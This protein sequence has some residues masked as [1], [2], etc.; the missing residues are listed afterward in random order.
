MA[1][2]STGVTTT[3]DDQSNGTSETAAAGGLR[4]RGRLRDG[5][6]VA[7][8]ANAP[9]K[10]ALRA[11]LARK[12]IYVVAIN[13]RR[14]FAPGIDPTTLATGLTQLAKLLDA[15]VP[16]TD[17]LVAVAASHRGTKAGE[18]LGVALDR[19]RRGVANGATLA[20]SFAAVGIVDRFGVELIHVGESTGRLTEVLSAIAIRLSRR[21]Q[22]R[23]ALQKALAYPLTVLAIALL[24]TVV[25]LVEIVPRFAEIYRQFGADLP[26]VTA[27]VVGV[28]D[29]IR[30]SLVYLIAIGALG[31]ALVIVGRR[32]DW[33]MPAKVDEALLALPIVGTI[34]RAGQLADAVR[35]LLIAIES[36]MPVVDALDLAH[37]TSHGR[38]RREL[39]TLSERVQEGDS[40]ARA[41]A[42]LGTFPPIVTTMVAAGETAGDLAPMLRHVADQYD[43]VRERSTAI[44]TALAEPLVMVVLGGL[45]GGILIA[46]YLPIF[47]LGNVLGGS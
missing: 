39:H 15:S 20:Q 19:A 10:R 3:V 24:V 46:L 8:D 2:T 47:G 16:L 25:M 35:T 14:R 43:E 28:S 12:G 5:A 45:V 13:R 9:G 31:G 29:T 11:M 4:W 27:F 23:K 40:I 21:Q 33:A 37:S 6:S 41:M 42:S 18:K 17:A 44:L 1:G 36:G 32:I 26:A 22:N 7:G 34:R 30:R 38:L